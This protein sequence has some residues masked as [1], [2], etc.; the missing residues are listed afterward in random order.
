MT[1]LPAAVLTA[2]I[3]AYWL[4]VGVMIVRVRRKTRKQPG[5][6]PRQRLERLMWL[7]WVPLVA[8]WVTL[9]YL[10]ATRSVPPWAVPD[11]VRDP[12]WTA[13]RWAAAAIAVACLGLSIE[14]WV[15]MGSRWRM[16]VVP[17]E[18]TELVT[19]GLYAWI[20]HPIYAL[21]IILMI[22]S[23][24]ILPTAPMLAVAAIHLSLMVIKARNEEAFLHGVHGE[25]YAR[26]CAQTGRFFPHFTGRAASARRDG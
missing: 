19:S 23:A 16:A 17:G 10:A 13:L 7:V 6:I 3:W 15:R 1:D 2:T 11:F 26:Y 12:P 14:C 21:S 4:C 18:R 5:V 20:R 24:I 9:P 8:A 25:V 22:S